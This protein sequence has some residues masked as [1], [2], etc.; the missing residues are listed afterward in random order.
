MSYRQGGEFTK[1]QMKYF[2]E[3]LDDNFMKAIH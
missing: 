2:F 3:Y 1:E